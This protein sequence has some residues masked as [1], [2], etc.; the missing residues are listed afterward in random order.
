MF[1]KK[2]QFNRINF[3]TSRLTRVRTARILLLTGQ[4]MFY[5]GLVA[6][7]GLPRCKGN[8]VNT[9]FC[10]P[11]RDTLLSNQKTEKLNFDTNYITI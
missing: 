7:S 5:Y 10:G 4:Y 8:A 6:S 1:N 2:R 9:T 11:T 3:G